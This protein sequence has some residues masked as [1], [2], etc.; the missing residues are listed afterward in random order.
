MVILKRETFNTLRQIPN[1]EVDLTEAIKDRFIAN[2]NYSA[3]L[4]FKNK[5]KSFRISMT[6]EV[7]DMWGE[8]LLAI[9]N[10]PYT[11]AKDIETI[12]E[13]CVVLDI[14]IED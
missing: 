4:A 12:V 14:N 3:M 2:F 11:H 10:F 9:T 13:D 8:H 1:Y 7:F 5:E 6:K